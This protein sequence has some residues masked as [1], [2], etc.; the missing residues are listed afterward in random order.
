LYS[1]NYTTSITFQNET[2]PYYP[3]VD[4]DLP[5]NIVSTSF[6]DTLTPSNSRLDAIGGDY[7]GDTVKSVGIWSDEANE[8]A[9]KLMYSKI[10]S[11]KP[12]CSSLFAIAKG[13]LNG[14]YSATK[15]PF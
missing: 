3:I 1:T 13:C 14:L 7:D 9:E 5:H 15:H 10:F 12:D 8:E 11:I 2:F 4:P 6:A